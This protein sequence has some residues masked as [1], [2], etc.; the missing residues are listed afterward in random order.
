MRLLNILGVDEKHHF[1]N[2]KLRKKDIQRRGGGG[3]MGCVFRIYF[4]SLYVWK[5]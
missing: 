5:D 1:K 4:I 2:G 3:I